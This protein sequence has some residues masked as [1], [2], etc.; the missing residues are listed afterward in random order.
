MGIG[1][2]T[3]K[4]L[5]GRS[6][7]MCAYPDCKKELVMDETETDD[8]SV[9]GEEAHIVARKKDGPRGESDLDIEQRDK[10]DNLILL[11][12]VH[13]KIIDD[14]PKH[15]TVEKLKEFKKTHEEWIK[16][17]LQIDPQKQRDDEVYSTYLDKIIQLANAENWKAW[18]SYLYGG[19][20]ARMNKEQY[21][22]L[23]ALVEYILSRVWSHRYTK[24]EASIQNLK[25]VTNDFLNVFDEHAEEVG[26]DG[27]WTKKFYKIDEWDTELYE[28]LH[29]KYRYHI[30]LVLDLTSE[31]TRAMNYVF[32][33][34]RANLLPSYRLEEGV[35]LIEDGPS[36][37]MTWRTYRLEYRD[38]ERTDYPYPGLKEFMEIRKSRDL[39]YGEGFSKD[40]FPMDFE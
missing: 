3:H 23:R 16:S 10:Y 5:W 36:M 6:G 9:I 37:E 7:N 33:N 13:H 34:V 15:Y 26:D 40:Y 20:H 32:D 28:K 39:H 19:G 31:L 14:Q 21:E 35:L 38:K 4:M 17:T 29:A 18:T 27:I 1:I 2:K 22:N 24:L 12:S 25:N 11:C 30:Q 8:P